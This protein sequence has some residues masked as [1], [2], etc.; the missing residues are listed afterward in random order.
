MQFCLF[1]SKVA[2]LK[3]PSLSL[4]IITGIVISSSFFHVIYDF[5]HTC[6]TCLS[7]KP[8]YPIL[9]NLF[10]EI[11]FRTL[12]ILVAPIC[13]FSFSIT[14]FLRE[15]DQDCVLGQDMVDNNFASFIK[16]FFISLATYLQD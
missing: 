3:F 13:I 4:Y 9:F 7:S 6:V 12:Y 16:P 5:T 8:N 14:S 15:D 11:H 2:T 1:W 10:Q